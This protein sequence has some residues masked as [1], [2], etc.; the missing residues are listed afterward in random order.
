M[1]GSVDYYK[2][3]QVHYLAEPEVIESAYKRLAKKY[4]PDV[5]KAKDSD[6]RMKQINEAYEV[7]S[8]A[9]KRKKYDAEKDTKQDNVENKNSKKI[10]EA[11][12]IPAKIIL[13][14]YFTYIKD[15]DFTNAYELISSI[16]KKNISLEDFIKWQCVVSKIFHLQDFDCKASKVD[17]NI[18]LSGLIYGKV[19][20]FTVVTIEHN[21]VMNRLEKDII[22]KKVVLEKRGWHINIGYQDLKPFIAK[23]EELNELLTAKSVI[24][25][26]IEVYGNTDYLTGLLNKKGFIEVTEKEVWRYNRY[27]NT[28]SIML[29]EIDYR[30][31]NASG[32][33]EFRHYSIEWV[34]KILKDNFR[35]LDSIGRW[36]E[37]SFIILMPETN[38]SNSIKAALK[39]NKIFTTQEFL[40]N[41]K[42][43]KLKI[44]IG[45]E[46]FKDSLVKTLEVLHHYTGIAKKCGDNCI[47]SSIG[48]ICDNQS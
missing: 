46:E 39:I 4:H 3:L 12:V 34:S 44:C 14:K 13:D 5:S 17:E 36:G 15:R 31:K 26:M 11:S 25:E 6:I 7:L 9:N 22:S 40:F 23:L 20:D 37:T 43:Y 35:K 47:V 32:W 1:M 24:N 33:Q 21:L 45:I 42:I 30:N 38:L 27:G 19:I 48:N 16:E 28:F 18:M 41:N 29:L 10:D 8:D 2:I